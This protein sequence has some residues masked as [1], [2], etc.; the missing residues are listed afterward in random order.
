MDVDNQNADKKNALFIIAITIQHNISIL[1]I[2]NMM[3]VIIKRVIKCF[4]NI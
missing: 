2:N 1:L 3:F 4:F